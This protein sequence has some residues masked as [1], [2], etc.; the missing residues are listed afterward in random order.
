MAVGSIIA[1]GLDRG[2]HT[3]ERHRIGVG[4]VKVMDPGIAAALFVV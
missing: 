3:L 2:Q 1:A 4:E